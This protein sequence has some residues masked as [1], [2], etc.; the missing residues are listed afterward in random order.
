MGEAQMNKDK[1]CTDMA[2]VHD[3]AFDDSVKL[4]VE[5]SVKRCESWLLATT[6][7]VRRQVL[8]KYKIGGPRAR[9]QRGKERIKGCRSRLEA[10][11]LLAEGV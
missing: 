8:A 11:T 5:T 3:F 7:R 1:V 9:A 4:S 2:R 6:K 10:C